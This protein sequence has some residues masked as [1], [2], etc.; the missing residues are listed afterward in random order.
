M[1][2]YR[3]VFLI[4]ICSPLIVLNAIQFNFIYTASSPALPLNK[5]HWQEKQDFFL[6][7]EG[8]LE[9]NQAHMVGQMEEKEREAQ[10]HISHMPLH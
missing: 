2:S 8:N 5:Q 7:T 9:Q 6:L 4:D 1:K 10:T 3:Y